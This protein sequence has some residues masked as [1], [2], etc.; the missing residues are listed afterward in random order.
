VYFNANLQVTI[1]GFP[2]TTVVSV[3]INNDS[4][5]VGSYAE[6][7][8]P[9]NSYIAYSNPNNL[10]TYLTA[11]RTDLF[12]QGSRLTVI[13][14][15][16]GYDN[17]TVF[18]GFVY[19]FILGQPLTIKAADYIYLLNLNVFGSQNVKVT[20]KSGTKIKDSGKGVNYPSVT[21]VTLLQQLIAFTNSVI[22]SELPTN[23]PPLLE[24]TLP[25]PGITFQNLTFVSMSPAAILE[26]LKKNLYFNITLFNNKLYVNLASNTLAS[27]PLATITNV[28]KSSLQKNTTVFERIRMKAWFIN[29]NGTRS[30][31]EVGDINGQQK[32]CFFYAVKNV[33]DQYAT[34]ANQALLQAQQRH[35]RGELTTL[36]YPFVDLYYKI[37]YSDARYPEKNGNYVVIGVEITLNE[38]GFHRK[39]KL[40]Y[41]DNATY[42]FLSTSGQTVIQSGNSL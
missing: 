35:Y 18:D 4:A 19:D 32:E 10:T 34:L 29:T 26:Y 1:N 17:Q 37:P 21:L 20:N 24:L 31:F 28:I 41:L 25:V 2:L 30:Y 27:V 9:L 40:A 15:Y 11:I 33:G 42:T 22:Q 8:V 6:I 5:K 23:T 12:P 7:V 3:K 13:A 16:E 14:S 38:S 36:L 39:L